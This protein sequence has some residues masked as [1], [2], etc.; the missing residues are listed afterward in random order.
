MIDS[1][2]R[3]FYN[4]YDC[5]EDSE[6]F[7]QVRERIENMYSFTYLQRITPKWNQGLTGDLL[8]AS[9]LRRQEDFYR[10]YLKAYEGK[11]RV[12]VIISDAFRYECAKELMESLELDEKCTPKLEAMIGSLPSITSVGMASLLP[13]ENMRVD[14]NLNVT[15]DGQPCGDLVSRDKILKARNENNI[16]LSFDEIA[17]ANTERTKE[18]LQKKNIVYIYHNQ[19]D[20]RGDK[21]ASEN[22][23]FNACAEAVKEIHKL[24]RKLTMTV[25]AAKF[26]ITADHGFLYKRDRL[27]EFDK[28]SY[29]KE[30]CTCANK[31]FLVTKQQMNDTGMMSRQMSYMN[32]LYVTTPIGADIFKTPGGGQ[33]YVH[34]GSS[35][36]EILI[37]VVELTMNSRAVAYD[38]VDV[39][40]TS[41]TRKVTNLITFFDFIQTEKVTDTMKPRNLV[42]YFTTKEGEKISFDVPIVANSREE[43]PEKRTF[44]EKFTLKSREYKYG[45]KYY[46]VLADANDEKNILQQY[47]FMIDIAFVD[48]F[49]F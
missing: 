48:D 28:V 30:L 49:G 16:A 38:Y 35:L 36:Q 15:I 41:T 23:V 6:R 19:I 11:K 39:V 9:G 14:E 40:L 10:N 37:P 32:M 18:L 7:S 8:V 21:A 27:Q 13:H 26:F 33:N 1:Y 47:E 22:E 5:I 43:A 3:W 17:G 42:A 31:R 44:H 29:T 2:Y 4:A 45:D 20:A 12:I 46:L 25:S 24:V 34:G